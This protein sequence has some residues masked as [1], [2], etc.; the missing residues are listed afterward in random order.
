MPK[1]RQTC[2]ECSM[3]RQKCDRNLP[4]SRCVKRGEPE[5]CTREWPTDGYD[6]KKHRIYPRPEKNSQGSPVVSNKNEGSQASPTPST[7]HHVDNVV[8]PALRGGGTSSTPRLLQDLQNHAPPQSTSTHRD[9]GIDQEKEASVLE[10]LTWGRGNLADY[11]VKSFDLLRE[12]FKNNSRPPCPEQEY[13]NGFGNTNAQQVSFL[14]LLLP[15]REQIFHLVD[16]HINTV[17]WYH[18]CFHGFSF[19]GELQ[20]HCNGPTGLQVANTDLRWSALLFSIMAGSMA[21]AHDHL[22]SSWGFQ[23]AEKYKLTRQ[24]YKAALSCLNLAD[25]MWRH[26]LYSVQ[27]VC[28]LT[29]SGH[30]LGFSNTQSTLQGAA[31]KIAQ[32]LGLQRLAHEPDESILNDQD[33]TPAKRDKIVK[34]EVGRRVW[35]QICN[36]DWFSIP[37]SEMYSIQRTHFSTIRPQHIDDR[38]LLPMPAHEPSSTSFAR[39]INDIASIMPQA[40]DASVTAS[41]LYT[42]YEQVLHYDAKM[43]SLSTDGTPSYF[44]MIEPI[45]PEWPDWVPW[46]RRSLRLCFA[47]KTIMIHRSFLGKSLTDP[48]FEHTRKT[49]MEA[50]K[51]IL[52]EARQAL[53]H[54]EG[55]MLWIDQAFMVAAGITLSLDIFHKPPTDAEFDE[56]RK[57]VE[58][59]I[60][61]LSKFDHSMIAIRGVRLLSS[62]LAEQAR[63]SAEKS[64]NSYNKKRARDEES[65]ATLD[66]AA[67]TPSMLNI[68]NNSFSSAFK[69]QK[70]DVPKFLESFVGSGNNYS[71]SL[72]PSFQGDAGTPSQ[73]GGNDTI[74]PS[75]MNM[76]GDVVLG[77][78]KLGNVLL[79]QPS[80]DRLPPISSVTSRTP[81]PPQSAPDLPVEYDYEAFEQIFPPHA[82]ISNSFLFEDL[83]NFEL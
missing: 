57:H 10:F 40:H 76:N 13:S 81:A 24:W 60:N 4:C 80:Q 79:Q 75:P 37:F 42:K 18:A 53:D 32:G 72:R 39:S 7:T 50:A 5:K 83:L 9:T 34:R 27:A 38:T 67:P 33:L 55:P 62:L 49:C 30:I 71:Q 70:F 23:K 35:S 17:L 12:P 77:N 64:I 68:S 59:T 20:S 54:S 14:Q 66:G 48:T 78:G 61:M 44:S 43:K 47:H 69:K 82:G 31:L 52:K 22:T 73:G 15:R 65:G 51:T 56:H 11:Q 6:P 41:T 74:V 36:Q 8:H 21:C 25:Y 1:E 3:R 26:H 28:V 19:R 16:Y 46:A 63:L 2:T 29:M 58:T 45:S